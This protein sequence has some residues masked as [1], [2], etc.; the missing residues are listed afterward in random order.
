MQKNF[1]SLNVCGVRSERSLRRRMSR[2][3]SAKPRPPAGRLGSSQVSYARK[4]FDKEPHWG[5][6]TQHK[7]PKK[8]PDE[9][10]MAAKALFFSL[11]RDNSGS[12]DA[13]ELGMM[14]RALGQNPTE[15]ELKALIDSVDGADGDEADG[16]IQLREFLKLYADAIDATGKKVNKVDKSDVNNVFTC[17][18][19]DL[20]VRLPAPTQPLTPLLTYIL[21]PRSN[22]ALSAPSSAPERPSSLVICD[23]APVAQDPKS[24]VETTNVQAKLIEDF[25][26]AVDLNEIFGLSGTLTKMDVAALLEVDMN[27]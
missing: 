6:L 24:V 5:V 26:L 20:K 8:I 13:D 17:F 11:D 10:M 12:I 21:T 16:Q 1:R 15:E 25:E 14:L 3:G 22:S 2:R 23:G 7:L 18:G 19:G 9:A 27:T 4:P